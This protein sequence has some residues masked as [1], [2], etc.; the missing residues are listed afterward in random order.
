MARLPQLREEKLHGHRL[1]FFHVLTDVAQGAPAL[2]IAAYSTDENG[3]VDVK[4][5]RK[6]E[7]ASVI[8]SCCRG[9][10]KSIACRLLLQS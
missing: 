7:L 2:C 1:F 5:E 6:I 10:S 4:N 3:R 9:S 8:A